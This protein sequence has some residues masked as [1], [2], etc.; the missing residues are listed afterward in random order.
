MPA[1]FDELLAEGLAVDVEASWGAG[2]L[3]GRYLPGELPWTWRG[4]AQDLVRRAGSVLD[5]GTGDGEAL[6]DLAPLPPLTV[7]TEEWLPTVP[8]AVRTLRPLGA[9]VVVARGADD[10]DEP[11]RGDRALPFAD[12]SF[13]LILNR[14]EAFDADD[15]RRMLRPGG[16]FVTQQVGHEEGASVRAL[17][18]LAPD[19][20]TWHLRQAERQLRESGLSVVDEGEA[21]PVTWFTDVAALVAYLRSVPWE[22]PEFDASGFEVQLRRLHERCT[23]DGHLEII[24]HRFHLTALRP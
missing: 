11:Q 8:A 16:S 9:H 1:G 15:V 22:V 20:T 10:N 12:G 24:G 2:F 4:L 19:G 5:Q 18:G 7:A 3:P 21:R 6:A 23:R 14:H 17:L 13:D